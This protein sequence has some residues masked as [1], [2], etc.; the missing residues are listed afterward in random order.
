MVME[1]IMSNSEKTADVIA[2]ESFKISFPLEG[3]SIECVAATFY[4][5]GYA[6]S[7]IR[8]AWWKD[9]TDKQKNSKLQDDDENRG[10]LNLVK[11]R[12]FKY[13][14]QGLH[15]PSFVYEKE[16]KQKQIKVY[17]TT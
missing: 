15:Q 17:K 1:N 6:L 11:K 7:P 13:F 2:S 14:N 8:L 9:T 10:K 5:F 4:R 3:T 16:L 12:N